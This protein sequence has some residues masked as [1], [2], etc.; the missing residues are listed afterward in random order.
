MNSGK[1]NDV[2]G[3]R[4]DISPLPSVLQMS[5]SRESFTRR[6]ASLNAEAALKCLTEAS[7]KLRTS[8]YLSRKRNSPAGSPSAKKPKSDVITAM[9]CSTSAFG[10]NA[11]I[12]DDEQQTLKPITKHSTGDEEIESKSVV[13][14]PSLSPD[15]YVR[16]TASLNATACMSALLS[17]SKKPKLSSSKGDNSET[18]AVEDDVKSEPVADTKVVEN[19]ESAS[20]SDVLEIVSV[21]GVEDEVQPTSSVAVVDPSRECSNESKKSLVVPVSEEAVQ[22]LVE[23]GAEVVAKTTQRRPSK[24]S[25]RVRTKFKCIVHICNHAMKMCSIQIYHENIVAVLFAVFTIDHPIT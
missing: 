25:R 12:S 14:L 3:E 15:F 18:V 4:E 2:K 23:E 1:N 13:S 8:S 17:P 11:F 16:R 5:P 22:R 19:Q 6:T 7:R 21:G 20:D 10:E 9:Q 24:Y